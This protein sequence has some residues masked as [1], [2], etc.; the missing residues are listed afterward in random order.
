MKYLIVN[1]DDF[2][3]TRG[4]NEGIA[5]AFKS[6]IVTSTTI[7]A[8]GDAFA[9]AVDI[10]RANPGLG[11]GCHLALVGGSPVALARDVVSLLDDGKLPATLTRLM[12]KL[13]GRGVQDEHIEGELR[14]QVERVVAAGITPSHFDSHKHSHTHPRVMKALARV[15]VEFG[16]KSVRN[17]FE[18]VLASAPLGPAARQ[19]RRVYLK[20]YAMSAAVSVRA[21]AFKRLAREHCL[22]TPDFFYGVRLTGLLDAEAIKSMIESLKDG[23]TELMCHPGVY[24]EDL[25]QARTRL[26]HQ[27]QRELDALIDSR[28]PRAIDELG[29]KLISYR[30]LGSESSVCSA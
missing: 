9:E 22:G 28:L 3:F 6:G 13:A 30:E 21:R 15:A 7:M 18:S 14:A 2:G 26:K 24:G 20:Q 25:G 19:A 27:R 16:I 29:V 5:L 23:T 1:A 4:V 12:T 10:A 17:P 11:V 8:N